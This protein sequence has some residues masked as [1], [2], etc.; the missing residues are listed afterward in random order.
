M[1]LQIDRGETVGIVGRNGSGKS[2]LL[3]IISRVVSASSGWLTIR[4]RVSALLE[5]GTGF[6][7]ELT[8]LENIFF[9][10]TLLGYRR[11]QIEAK[12][13]EILR[14]ADIG[15]FV[16]QPIK[17]YSSGMLG[18][19]GFAVAAAFDPDILIVDEALAVGDEA[20]QRQV[21]RPHQGHPGPRRGNPLRLALGRGGDRAVRS[22]VAHGP[23]RRSSWR[24]RPRRSSRTI[25]G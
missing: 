16:R 11:E 17:S 6:N 22:G 12:L 1:S 20:F 10:A 2:T 5:L 4:G 8:G 24:A 23:R 3:K 14:F 15:D 21:L 18:R 7:P 9:N 13:P 25:T 19:L